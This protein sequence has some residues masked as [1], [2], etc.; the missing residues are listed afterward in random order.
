M[1]R[2]C[3]VH[4]TVKVRMNRK[5]ALYSYPHSKKTS[6]PPSPASGH[7]MRVKSPYVV[8]VGNVF[9]QVLCCTEQYKYI[10]YFY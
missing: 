5:L 4:C 2:I 9:V 8:R 3:I 7:Q 1:C 10:V 6:N